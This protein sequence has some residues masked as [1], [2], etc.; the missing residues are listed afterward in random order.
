MEASYLPGV[1]YEYLA[2]VH[3]R[4][5]RSTGWTAPAPQ[6]PRS[7]APGRPIRIGFFSADFRYHPVGNFLIPL[8]GNHDRGR[9]E[10]V[11]FNSSPSGGDPLT[12]VLRQWAEFVEIH[13]QSDDEVH[14]LALRHALD[15]AVDLSGHSRHHRLD[16][17]A[18]RVAP[19]QISWAGYVGTTGVPSMDYLLADAVYVTAEEERHFTETVLRMPHSYAI[20]TPYGEVP[21]AAKRRFPADQLVFGCFNNPKKVNTDLLHLY[22]RILVNTDGLLLFKNYQVTADDF[23]RRVTDVFGRYGIADRAV[24][25]DWSPQRELLETYNDVDISLDTM[26]YNGGFTTCESLYMGVPVVSMRGRSFAARHT[27]SYA[28][29][30]GLSAMIAETPDDYVNRAV[31]LG[32]PR[33]VGQRA[34][35]RAHFLAS[36]VCDGPGFCRHFET[37][38]EQVVARGA[39][40]RRS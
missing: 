38:V 35:L 26:P 4:W 10:L 34:A 32:R 23:R 36:P 22:A 20:Y 3:G 13:G 14:A 1:D 28:I 12:Q 21:I 15:V 6:P 31:D 16:V 2:R 25:E 11:A 40:G 9:F 37:I 39:I 7:R 19:V 8:F 24:F 27:A 5:W 33:D 30:A 29:A 17:F 18:R